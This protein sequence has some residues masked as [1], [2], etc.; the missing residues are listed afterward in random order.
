M[1][2]LELLRRWVE[3]VQNKN[4]WPHYSDWT[5]HHFQL[6]SEEISEES[7]IKIDRNTIRKIVESVNNGKP[8]SPHISTKDA[9]V[10]YIGKKNWSQFTKSQQTPERSNKH[11]LIGAS[12]IIAALL[13]IAIVYFIPNNKEEH[14]EF[15][16]K[17]PEGLVP[18]TVEYNYNI[19][20]IK[21]DD[22]YID[23]GHIDPD[24]NYKLIKLQKNTFINKNCFHYPGD[25]NIRLLVDGETKVRDKV[26]INSDGWFVYAIDAASYISR[27]E[28]PELIK[29]VGFP[30]LQYIPF[31][32][33]LEK[34]ST[35]D[36]YFYIPQE[37][38]MAIEGQTVNHHLH[39]RN[40]RS[41]GLDMN[42]ANFSIRFK[43]DEFAETI[44]CSE[45]AIYLHCDKGLVGFKFAQ[46]GCER[47]TH[48]RVGRLFEMGKDYDLNHLII[49][50]KSFRTVSI[51]GTP[52]E[53]ILMLDGKELKTFVSDREFGEIRGMHFWFKGSPH[54]D[55]VK[56]ADGNGNIVFND[57]FNNL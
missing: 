3:L 46:K 43:D 8:Y 29:K 35:E 24:G 2:E 22:I 18:H 23:Y 51:K 34:Q 32:S 9:I 7:G 55:F 38:I 15:T 5:N 17:N 42:N 49:D 31:N 4:Q 41:F 33:V 26:W 40:F 57:E 13:A 6:L 30:Q 45:A 11:I 37:T 47:Y 44:Y 27:F 52:D 21:T 16:L 28:L 53:I 20:D 56:L 25:Y 48:Q 36:G 14:F 10:R 19:E 50:Y 12:V 1:N 39:L 54:I